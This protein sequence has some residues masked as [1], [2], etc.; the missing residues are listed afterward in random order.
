[1][2]G[3]C[4]SQRPKRQ[5]KTL[6]EVA[7]EHIRRRQR[8]PMIYTQWQLDAVVAAIKFETQREFA[9]QQRLA[10]E[11]FFI[12]HFIDQLWAAGLPAN[13]IFNV[14]HQ[15]VGIQELKQILVSKKKADIEKAQ[16][17]RIVL[18]MMEFFAR[19]K[20]H[21]DR[22]E[23][24]EVVGQAMLFGAWLERLT[25]HNR[26]GDARKHAQ[27]PTMKLLFAAKQK[28]DKDQL[29]GSKRKFDV[30]VAM[31]YEP[32]LKNVNVKT[33]TLENSLSKL[34][35]SLRE[36]EKMMAQIAFRG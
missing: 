15:G 10:R 14:D 29:P 33:R 24:D 36:G 9:H 22:N 3:P 21:I 5:P 27:S 31:E 17:A 2:K 18:D 26:S 25:N 6:R 13:T 20:T 23:W 30:Q 8:E 11:A 35:K 32:A 19:A 4:T 12:G 16:R 1:M 34:K 7:K 28:W